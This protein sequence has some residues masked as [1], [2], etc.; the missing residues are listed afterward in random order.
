MKKE[1]KQIG[2][3]FARA[4]F[5]IGSI[6]E[7][8]RTVD[9][10]FATET[11]VLRRNWDVGLFY[12][13]LSCKPANVR[14]ERLSA[15]VVPVLDNHTSYS[16]DNQLGVVIGFSIQNNECRATLKYSKRPDVDGVWQD[17]KDGI[18][19][20]I[21]AGYNVY[22]GEMVEK[23]GAIP[24]FTAT[25]WEVLEI[26]N[27]PV[28]ADHNSGT[29]SNDPVHDVTI[30]FTNKNSHTMTAAEKRSA[31]ILNACTAA[32]VSDEFAQSLIDN[33]EL[34][35]D[36]AREAIIA[37]LGKSITPAPAP[38]APAVPAKEGKKENTRASDILHAVRAAGIDNGLAF[39]QSLI[40]DANVTVESARASIISKLAENMST[41]KTQSASPAAVTGAD[42]VSKTRSAIITGVSL[43]SGAIKEANVDASL[44]AGARQYRGTSLLDIAKEC[45]TRAGISYSG[46]DKMEIVG[47]AITSSSSD[48]PVLLQGV[49]H[50]TL[51]A[52]YQAVSDTWT[53]FCLT[54]TVSD[55]RAHKRLRMGSFTRLDKIQENGEFK[56]K[57]ITDADSESI[58]AE[59]FGNIINVSRKMIVNDDLNA[60]SRLATMLGRAAARSIEV[61]VYSLL[62]SNPT[63]G[64]GNALFSVAHNNLL[65]GAAPSAI[66]FDKLRVAMGSQKDKDNNDIL[67]LRP[68]VLL[69][70]IAQG[71]TAKTI[72]DAL[73]DPDT[74]NKL[75]KPNLA[76]GIF[77]NIVDTA[78]IT[79][80]EYYAFADPMEEPV[81]EVAFLD[82]VQEPFLEQKEEFHVDGMAWKVRLDYGVGAIG[83]RGAVKNPGA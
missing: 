34:T 42:E 76:K 14:T 57:K 29:R 69:L 22:E 30:N 37:E 74:A 10:V 20:G 47:R 83:W 21:S 1:T 55:F 6:N 28:P 51:L 45:L 13:I 58:T 24:T 59:T 3:Q 71:G 5:D 82:G 26:S 49:I 50:K 80:N 33:A 67:D 35:V 16:V 60:F 27:A 64:D 32:K 73:Y 46:M 70:G 61:D 36:Q 8:E 39:A 44:L 41:A 9:V 19:R 38:A 62:A 25:D 66:E 7:A 18:L 68:S 15:G 54:G 53:R 2:K 77:N 4:L 40:D 17:I 11:P 65:T 48:F 23:T 56:N 31:D 43:R 72:N 12:E 81:L 79:G 78:R 75:Q 52:N 63:M